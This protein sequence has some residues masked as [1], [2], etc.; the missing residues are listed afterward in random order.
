MPHRYI[1]S[2]VYD[3]PFGKGRRYAFG[4]PVLDALAGGW[5]LGGVTEFRSGSVY[6]AVEQT[7]RSNTFSH[8]QR[9]QLVADPALDSNR[10]RGD[11]IAQYFKTAAS[12]APGDGVFGSSPRTI[13]CG[14]GA[15]L[16]DL[17]AY[18]WFVFTERY[19]LQLRGD[20]FNIANRPNF[21]PPAAVRGR[22]DFGRIGAI[23]AGS[24]GRQIQ[25]AL[26]FEF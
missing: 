12:A 8:S 19:R 5:G 15:A 18:K 20:F 22:G 11:L 24:T 14:P 25:L 2:V 3:L 16:I 26:R 23:A 10:P 13:C 4:S 7:N 21:A 17:S 9:P 1:T 6:G